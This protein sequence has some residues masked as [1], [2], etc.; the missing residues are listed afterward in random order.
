MDKNYYTEKNTNSIFNKLQW[1]LLIII[2]LANFWATWNTYAILDTVYGLA[3]LMC[4]AVMLVLIISN[5]SRNMK[6]WDAFCIICFIVWSAIMMYAFDVAHPTHGDRTFLF[7]TMDS[8]A[9]SF[10]RMLILI[11]PCIAIVDY[12]KIYKSKYTKF[13]FLIILIT[14]TFFMARAIEV[15]PDAVRARAT[16]AFAGYEYLLKGVPDYAHVYGA[17]I[18][19]PAILYRR[20]DTRGFE[21]HCYTLI[22]ILMAYIIIFSQFATALLVMLV[23]ILVYY[24]IISNKKNRLFIFFLGVLLVIIVV[25]LDGGADI[26]YWLSDKVEGAWSIKLEDIALTLS[27]KEDSGM[28]SSRFSY[29]KDSLNSFLNDPLFGLLFKDGKIG[30]HATAIDILGLTGIF[31]FIPFGVCVTCNFLKMYKNAFNLAGKAV[32][33]SCFVQFVVLAF[34]KNVISAMAIFLAYFVVVPVILKAKEREQS[35]A[36]KIK[37]VVVR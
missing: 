20:S 14:G 24:F 9:L 2:F 8:Y 6:I 26:F 3:T 12:N 15:N 5:H 23:G 11:L 4:F 1:I 18:I 32:A 17:A 10:I 33:I 30:G 21:K 7:F 16:M 35:D 28:V 37:E 36:Q 22:I 34:S 13:L 25:F 19:F 31:G 29:Y 27:G